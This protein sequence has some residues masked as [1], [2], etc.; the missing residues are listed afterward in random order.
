M[1]GHS[2]LIE[3]RPHGLGRDACVTEVGD[4]RHGVSLGELAAVRPEHEAVVDVLGGLGAERLG[5]LP[6]ELLVGTMVGPPHDMGDLVL[7][8]VDHG[9]EMVGRGPVRT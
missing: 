8:V 9:G 2:Q 4:G 3:V 5:Q 6:V 1:L 7:D